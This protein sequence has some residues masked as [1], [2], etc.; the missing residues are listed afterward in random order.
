MKSDRSFQIRNPKDVFS[1]MSSKFT[2]TFT[3]DQMAEILQD[4][5]NIE[6]QIN[7]EPMV[8]TYCLNPP[9]IRRFSRRCWDIRCDD[10]SDSP[11]RAIGGSR[12]EAISHWDKACTK[13]SGNCRNVQSIVKSVE[14]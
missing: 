13:F 6:V 8:C 9:K 12:E 10:C 5:L 11:I 3:E 4:A 7:F 1:D 14:S 2:D